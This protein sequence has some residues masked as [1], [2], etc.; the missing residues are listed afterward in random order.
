MGQLDFESRLQE[1][2]S[3]VYYKVDYVARYIAQAQE[4]YNDDRDDEARKALE[5]VVA[6]LLEAG[7]DWAAQKVA[8]YLKFM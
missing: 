6:L 4:Y 3:S 5:N 8:Y 1:S 7:Q 2:I